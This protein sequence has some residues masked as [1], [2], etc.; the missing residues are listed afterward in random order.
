MKIWGMI[1]A[2]GIACACYSNWKWPWVIIREYH[3]GY[4]DIIKPVLIKKST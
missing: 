2:P 3:I 1:L 4:K